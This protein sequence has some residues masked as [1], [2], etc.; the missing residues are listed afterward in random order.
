MNKERTVQD[1]F[2][3]ERENENRIEEIQE[4]LECLK[5]ELKN[6]KNYKQVLNKN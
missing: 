3:D 5:E 6:R 1:V 4:E 2:D